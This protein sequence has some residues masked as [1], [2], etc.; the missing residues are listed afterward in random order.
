MTRPY[1]VAPKGKNHLDL[2]DMAKRNFLASPWVA[3][4]LG[5]LLSA[6]ATRPVMRGSGESPEVQISGVEDPSRE[7]MANISKPY[8]SPLGDIPLDV[9]PLTEQWIKYFQGRGRRYMEVYLQR[10]SRYLPMMKNTLRENGLPEDLVYVSLIESGFS[11]LAHSHANAVGYWQFIRATGKRYGLTVD[12]FIDERRD[13]VLSTRAA[14]EYFKALYN[15]FGS[16]HLALASYNVG[17]NRVKRAVMKYYTR[18]FWEL[19]KRRKAFPKETKHYV[20]KFIAATLIA[21]NPENYGFTSINYEPPL[22]FDT[23]ALVNPISMAKLAQTMNVDEKELKLLNPK[24]R[25]DYVP[26]YRGG[27]TVIRVP[28]GMTQV[29]TAAIPASLSAQPKVISADYYFYRVKRGDSLSTIA[30]KHRTSIATLRRLNNL[31]NRSLLRVGQRL[32]VP[33]RGGSYVSYEMPTSESGKVAS[34]QTEES[35]TSSANDSAA[36]TS[37]VH[38]VRRGENLTLIARKY[39]LSVNQLRRLNK[40]SNRAILRAGQTLRLKEDEPAGSD[41]S[42][43]VQNSKRSPVTNRSRNLASR[44][45]TK[46]TQKMVKDV[47]K[48]SKALAK[49]A[50]RH[51]VRRGETLAQIAMRY[52]VSVGAIA[53]HNQIKNKS[54]LLAG[55]ELVIPH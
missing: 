53:K 15:L 44:S 30:R 40:L 38:V 3:V 48:R 23:V 9:T 32:R 2:T 18:D 29:A 31:G 20:P 46:G 16:W 11:P 33:D 8:Q 47:V 10:S 12:P 17:E 42:S 13:P 5:L 24:F 50:R 26:Q 14:A 28:V 21:K 1:L 37:E 6:C 25:G 52:K 55:S 19:A 49:S 54:R 51:K 4:S 22:A 34:E 7:V 27:E 39:G 41:K 35:Q 36:T 45:R 43:S